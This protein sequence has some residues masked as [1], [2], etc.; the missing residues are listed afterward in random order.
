MIIITIILSHV[1]LD[2]I[3]ELPAQ[4]ANWWPV[5]I[6]RGYSDQFVVIYK[7]I[8]ENITTITVCFYVL[9]I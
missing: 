2:I 8:T 9:T 5:S 6:I 4:N 1:Y 7:H 3:I